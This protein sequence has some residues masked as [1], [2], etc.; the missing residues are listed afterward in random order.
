MARK[1]GLDDV[2]AE[3]LRRRYGAA[4]ERQSLREL[5]SYFNKRVLQAAFEQTGETPLDEEVSNV[6][7]LLTNDD[8]RDKMDRPF[9]LASRM[10]AVTTSPLE[11]LRTDSG[12]SLGGFDVFVAVTVT[13][14]ECHTRRNL[15]ELLTHRGCDCCVV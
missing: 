6:Y 8:V 13:C 1:H 3:L 5:E 15:R 10:S 9:R 4:E 14:T 11:H 12:F 7:R 2:E